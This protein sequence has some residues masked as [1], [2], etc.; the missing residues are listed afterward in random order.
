MGREG[1]GGPVSTITTNPSLTVP[2]GNWQS[3]DRGH[4]GRDKRRDRNLAA[5]G[6]PS[7]ST[8]QPPSDSRAGEGVGPSPTGIRVQNLGTQGTPPVAKRHHNPVPD[9]PTTGPRSLTP[10]PKPAPTPELT[11]HGMDHSHR[12]TPTV[13]PLVTG[14]NEH[15]RPQSTTTQ[16]GTWWENSCPH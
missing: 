9:P 5:R 4:P 2:K 8:R 10:D 12:E 16:D 11:A 7:S 3:N 13:G 1:L 6:H 14:S 15:S